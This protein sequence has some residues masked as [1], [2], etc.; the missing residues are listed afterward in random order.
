MTN[1]EKNQKRMEAANM[2]SAIAKQIDHLSAFLDTH[3]DDCFYVGSKDGMY[4]QDLDHH[5]DQYSRLAK[6]CRRTIEEA[7]EENQKS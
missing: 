6:S 1:E 7:I 5:V 3:Y 2:A 4:H